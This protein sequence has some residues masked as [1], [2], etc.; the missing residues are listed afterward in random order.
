MVPVAGPPLDEKQVKRAELVES[1]T[2]RLAFK[3]FYRAFR[4]KEK[5]SFHAAK[6]FAMECFKILPVKV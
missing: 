4:A 6:V 1:P 2:T 5:T 3:D